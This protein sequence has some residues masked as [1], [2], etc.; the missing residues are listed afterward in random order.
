MIQQQKKYQFTELNAGRN[1][2]E[3]L[4]RKGGGMGNQ[5]EN[6]IGQRKKKNIVNKK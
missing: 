3:N 6:C 5:V 4:K 2:C 1:E